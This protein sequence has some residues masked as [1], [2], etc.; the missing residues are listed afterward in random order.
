M[1]Q[2]VFSAKMMQLA[3]VLLLA[4]SGATLISCE[5]MED[6]REGMNDPRASYSY[7]AST[8][9]DDFRDACIPFES[10]IRQ[11]IGSDVI[12]GGADDQVIRA[13]DE[14]YERIKPKFYGKKGGV[15]ISKVRHPDGKS[16][17]LKSYSF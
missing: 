15:F 2:T 5:K 13:C 3:L 4:V 6:E 9:T 11:A 7:C 16:K 17:N 1:K 12:A 10:A 8:P 14:C